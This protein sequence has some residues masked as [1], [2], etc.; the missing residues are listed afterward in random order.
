MGKFIAGFHHLQILIESFAQ[1][2]SNIEFII[3]TLTTTINKT[4]KALKILKQFPDG[5]GTV[6]IYGFWIDN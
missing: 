6:H 1:R 5:R 2:L 4:T 3:K